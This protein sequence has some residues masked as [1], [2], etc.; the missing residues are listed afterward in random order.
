MKDRSA[1]DK[2]LDELNKDELRELVREFAPAEFR[3]K[4]RL[5]SAPPEVRDADFLNYVS[6]IHSIF[7]DEIMDPDEI[8]EEFDTAFTRL[9]PFFTTH[10]TGMIVVFEMVAKQ[11]EDEVERGLFN[12]AWDGNFYSHSWAKHATKFI[13][14]VPLSSRSVVANKIVDI[15]LTNE[16]SYSW[17]F[18]HFLVSKGQENGQLSEVKSILLDP[19]NLSRF[20]KDDQKIINQAF[21]VEQLLSD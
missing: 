11:A 7:R 19:N 10:V 1:F 2:Y 9:H 5:A 17:S 21:T 6:K 12:D 18:A 13:Y 16:L 15:Y 14:E 4:I 3:D 20:Q 8:E